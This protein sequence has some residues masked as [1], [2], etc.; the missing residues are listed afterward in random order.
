MKKKKEPKKPG[1]EGWKEYFEGCRFIRDAGLSAKQKREAI[2]VV[3]FMSGESQK[4]IKEWLKKDRWPAQERGRSVRVDDQ[5]TVHY[6][7]E[8]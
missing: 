5:G 1:E 7:G 8:E 2:R 4:S 3:A 6:E